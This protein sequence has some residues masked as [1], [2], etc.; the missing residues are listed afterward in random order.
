MTSSHRLRWS[1]G[2]ATI[3]TT[4]AM[5]TDCSFTLPNGPFAPFARAPWLGTVS[6]TSISGHL[7]VLAGDFV[8]LPFGGK[9]GDAYGPPEWKA[10]MTQP[11]LGPIHGAAADREW[12]IVS[13][14]DS[15]VTLSLAYDADSAVEKIERV[16]TVRDGAPALDFVMRIFARRKASMSAGIHPNFRLPT[17]PGRLELKADFAFGLTH[18]GQ[19]VPGKQEFSKLS[20][21][22]RGD[23]ITDM[24]HIPL[25]PRT[26]KN[27]QMCG[28]KG[29]LT[30]TWLDENAGIVLDWDRNLMQSLMIWHTDGG[31]TGEPWNGQFRAVGL[32]PIASAF[33]L[34]TDL[35]AGPNPINTRGVKTSIDIDPAKP[36]EIWHSIRAFAA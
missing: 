12:T 4:A 23:E 1:H 35:S 16:I 18:P 8:G 34:H 33:D 28:M 36:L 30:A 22:P 21:T 31:I 32:E 25:S 19:T 7:R 5:L 3:I 9:R 13:G 20:A 2:D 6:D 17:D 24:S 26:D 11:N 10:L 14:D 15:T 27:V 29:P